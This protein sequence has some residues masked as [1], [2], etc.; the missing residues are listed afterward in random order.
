ML[1]TLPSIRSPTTRDNMGDMA[2]SGG[3]ETMK[4]GKDTEG[5]LEVLHVGLIFVSGRLL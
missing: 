3:F 1:V 5:W 2:F 4:A